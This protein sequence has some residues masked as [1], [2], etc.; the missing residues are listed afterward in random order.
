MSGYG[1]LTDGRRIAALAWPV[2]IGQV[3]VLAFGTIDTVL[4]S[5]FSALD[6]AALA[7]GNSAYVS[8][9]VGLMGV[10]L[11]ISPIVGQLFGAGKLREAGRQVH[12]STWLALALS[13]AGCALLLFPAPFLL[14]AHATG[15]LEAKVRSYLA[16][17]AFALPPALLLTVFRGFN[18][19][20]SRPKVVMLLQVAALI[21]KIPLSALFIFGASLELPWG[22]WRVAAHGA[23]G[24][25]IATA[26]V[27]VAQLLAAWFVLR[28]DP[29]YGSFAIGHKLQSPDRASLCALLKLGIPMGL[30]IGIEVTGFTFMALFISRIGETP[31]AGHQIAV[32]LVSLMF[33]VPM[34]LG[35]ATGTLVAQRIGAADP[36]DARRLGWHGLQVAIVEAAVVGAFVYGCRHSLLHAYTR[37]EVIISAALPLLGWVMLFHIVDA[38]QTLAAFVL[39]AH[40]IAVAPMVIYAVAIWGVGLGGGYVVAFDLFGLTPPLLQG[41]QGFWSAATAGLSVAAVGLCGFLAWVLRHESGSSDDPHR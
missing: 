16:Y 12:Q 21:L 38:A 22:T 37:D 35:S 24:C 31:V 40:R 23:P 17:L 34:A 3:A 18:T 15:E 11:G 20:V 33:M 6:L 28:R 8:I 30:S 36:Q 9:F 1:V 32:N 39:R 26:I 27:M 5:R 2:F 14:I 25:A 29:F 41:A 7:V 19:A 4:V 10:V 13:V